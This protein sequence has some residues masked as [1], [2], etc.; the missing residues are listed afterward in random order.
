VALSGQ[1][2]GFMAGLQTL[3]VVHGHFKCLCYVSKMSSLLTAYKELVALAGQLR[4]SYTA[5]LHTL[6][7]IHSHFKCLVMS[8]KCRYC[9]VQENYKEL[10]ALAAQLRESYTARLNTE[11]EALRQVWIVF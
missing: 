5:R 1:L 7:V 6:L 10:V 4:E 9:F 3:L 11:I 8:L 2:R